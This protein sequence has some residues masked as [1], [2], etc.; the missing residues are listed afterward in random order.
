MKKFSKNFYIKVA[1]V[2]VV[3]L[4]VMAISTLSIGR[5]DILSDVTNIVL[6]PVKKCVSF[7]YDKTSGVIE[8]FIKAGSYAEENELLKARI[9]IL[10]SDY[11]DIEAYKA[12]NERLLALL[13]MKSSMPQLNLQGASVISIESDNWYN[14]ITIDKGIG[15]GVKV[16][17]VVITAQGLVGTVYEVG[18]TWAKVREIIDMESSISAVCA[19]TGDR[20]VIEGDFNLAQSGRCKLN[21]LPKNAN[22]V[23]GDR[24]EISDTGSIYPKGVYIGKIVE[25]HDD[26][27][28][29]TL[30]AIVESEVNFNSLSEVLVG[31]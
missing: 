7:V 5:A 12:E 4:L 9:A 10:E 25:I 1:I 18:T 15:M 16:N 23:I 14:V 6:Q 13:N 24:I 30:T 28:G 8:S 22:V 26:D 19:R 17:D 27:D 20:G 31:R 3:I 21:Y 29:L 2:S 11:S